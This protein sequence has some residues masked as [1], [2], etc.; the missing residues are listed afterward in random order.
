[1][2]SYWVSLVLFFIKFFYRSMA[3]SMIKTLLEKGAIEL[4]GTKH[5]KMA[6]YTQKQ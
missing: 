5:S 3:R 4:V 6:V 1:M 2:W